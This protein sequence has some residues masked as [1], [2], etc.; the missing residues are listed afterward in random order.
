MQATAASVWSPRE[1]VHAG[2]GAAHSNRAP[3]C[4]GAPLPAGEGEATVPC[5]SASRLASS[6]HS[7]G[8]DVDELRGLRELGGRLGPGGLRK[9]RRGSGSV[10]AS[11]QPCSLHRGGLP[12]H[13]RRDGAGRAP[14]PRLNCVRQLFVT[15]TLGWAQRP[16]PTRGAVG[17]GQAWRCW[18]TASGTPVVPGKGPAVLSAPRKSP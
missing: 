6:T 16:P 8:S 9:H 3:C 12:S 15:G 7:D 4:W 2:T 5:C 10:A 13:Q 11:L 18:G 14:I 17:P 1:A